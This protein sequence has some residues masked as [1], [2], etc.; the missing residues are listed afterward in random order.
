MKEE[1]IEELM[2]SCLLTDE[3][4]VRVLVRVRMLVRVC[5]CVFVCAW[6]SRILASTRTNRWCVFARE[7]FSPPSPK[8][9]FSLLMAT[10]GNTLHGVLLQHTATHCMFRVLIL[11]LLRSSNF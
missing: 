9:L 6:K 7:V 2:D 10:H 11:D 3:E 4:M 5:I 1:K 8:K